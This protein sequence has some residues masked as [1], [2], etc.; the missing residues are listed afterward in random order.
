MIPSLISPL[1]ES[2]VPPPSR[3]AEYAAPATPVLETVFES[4]GYTVPEESAFTWIPG[5]VPVPEAVLVEEGGQMLLP[6]Q[7]PPHTV[8]TSAVTPV[9][10]LVIIEQFIP[11][12]PPTPDDMRHDTS[13]ESVRQT[14]RAKVFVV[15]ATEG[16]T[17]TAMCQGAQDIGPDFDKGGTLQC[18]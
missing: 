14:D 17:S 15:E 6:E 7:P 10:N 4:P 16:S 9:V 2:E 5:F 11:T 3:A 12:M 18:V 1:E 13:M 8:P